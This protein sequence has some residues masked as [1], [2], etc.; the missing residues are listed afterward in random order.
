MLC[1]S[2]PS[3]SKDHEVSLDRDEEVQLKSTNLSATLQKLYLW[4]KKLFE[5]VKVQPCDFEQSVLINH[6]IAR[7]LKRQIFWWCR[8]FF[9]CL[10]FCASAH[11]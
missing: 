2:L 9:M 8:R 11:L 7:F 6:I 3:S 10:I 5:E 4:E 1:A